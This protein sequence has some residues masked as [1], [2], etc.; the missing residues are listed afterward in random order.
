MEFSRRAGRGSCGAH[1]AERPPVDDEQHDRQGD[2]HRFGHQAQCEARDR[3]SVA[4]A[5]RARGIAGVVPQG[6]QAE[7]CADHVLALGNPRYRFHVQRMQGKQ[8]GHDGARACRTGE[9]PPHRE[10]EPHI[11]EMD[12]ETHQ[13]M[14][15]GVDAEQLHVEHVRDP[16][17][18]VPVRGL[19]RRERPSESGGRD[20]SQDVRVVRHVGWVVPG[21][22]SEVP[23][24]R[25]H[26]EAQR[27]RDDQ[28]ETRRQRD[29]ARRGRHGAW[30]RSRHDAA[31]G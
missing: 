19:V 18:R 23:Y 5:A 2:K 27:E 4:R 20:A 16:G 8:P 30:T 1:S 22:E 15:A 31:Q 12:D 17:E 25:E 21:Q 7:Q 10:Y 3:R 24:R 6:Q 29:S 13:M 28:H 14:R 26:D 9:A 11:K